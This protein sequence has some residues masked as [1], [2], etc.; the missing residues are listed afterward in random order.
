MSNYFVIGYRSNLF[1]PEGQQSA[2]F[3]YRWEVGT[4]TNIIIEVAMR[5]ACLIIKF[6]FNRN[7]SSVIANW[8]KVHKF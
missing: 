7:Y 2:F 6:A 8:Y 4:R 5:K 1:L 3:K